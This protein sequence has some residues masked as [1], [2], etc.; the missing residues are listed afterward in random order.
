MISSRY[1]C[2]KQLCENF[3]MRLK[4]TI[5]SEKRVFRPENNCI[6]ST[7]FKVRR[8]W[9][10]ISRANCFF[11]PKKVIKSKDICSNINASE[12]SF[13]SF[14]VIELSR[15]ILTRFLFNLDSFYLRAMW[16]N[17][18]IFSMWLLILTAGLYL[19]FLML[20]T[21]YDIDIF[22]HSRLLK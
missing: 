5:S 13:L 9:N 7:K 3:F 20:C 16:I 14:I 4:I 6:H 8:K 1:S 19:Y 22:F 12:R 15:N 17:Y 11:P 18:P 10:N 2:Q 21:W